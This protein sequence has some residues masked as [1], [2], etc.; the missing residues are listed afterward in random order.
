MADDPFAFETFLRAI[1]VEYE[2]AAKAEPRRFLTI[3][4][5]A[6]RV[7]GRITGEERQRPAPALRAAAAR[8]TVARKRA[9]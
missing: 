6:A 3:G 8:A 1:A 4:E 2:T 5:A 7:L 9:P